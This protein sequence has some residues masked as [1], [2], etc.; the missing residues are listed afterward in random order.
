MILQRPRTKRASDMRRPQR[1][2]QPYYFWCWSQERAPRC[3][4]GAALIA[5]GDERRND[6]IDDTT[7]TPMTIATIVIV[8]AVAANLDVKDATIRKKATAWQWVNAES[9]ARATSVEQRRQKIRERNATSVDVTKRVVATTVSGAYVTRRTPS[10][11]DGRAATTRA[12]ITTK[13]RSQA[14]KKKARTTTNT[15]ILPWRWLRP[16]KRQK[17]PVVSFLKSRARLLSPTTI[18]MPFSLRWRVFWAT[19][20][21]FGHLTVRASKKWFGQKLVWSKII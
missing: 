13:K 18:L 3:N 20:R 15:T 12:A 4:V 11:I 6:I 7:M 8:A 1:Y 2:N 21:P 5:Q 10:I 9:A 17:Q 14:K 19:V 16:P